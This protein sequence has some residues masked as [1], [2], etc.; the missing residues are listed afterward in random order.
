[1][2]IKLLALP[3]SDY[4]RNLDST[5]LNWLVCLRA[6][7]KQLK[8]TDL[9]AVHKIN[10][11]AVLDLSDGQISYDNDNSQ[12]DERI[13]RSWAELAA[14]GQAFQHLR[15]MMFGWQEHLSEWI[16]K[17][18][19]CFPS[20]CHIIITDCPG[21]HQKN[22]NIWEPISQA[23]GWNAQ[24]GKRSAKIL[25]PILEN[26]DFYFGSISG[27]YYDS[28]ELCDQLVHKKRPSLKA[29]LP[30]LEVWMQSPRRWSHIVDDFREFV[31]LPIM[32]FTKTE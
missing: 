24:R 2:E 30:I 14:S 25:R 18:T 8:V 13:M 21:M 10:N 16:F 11:L 12:F 17:Y 7:P 3:V 26:K 32:L 6:S 29:R 28:M 4:F 22:R 23:A 19:D 27:F 1:M 15:V 20:L 9:V 5:S 31:P